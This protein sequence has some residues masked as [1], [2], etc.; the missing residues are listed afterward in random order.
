[1][2]EVEHLL[3]VVTFLAFRLKNGSAKPAEIVQDPTTAAFYP[4]SADAI[5]ALEAIEYITEYL[6]EDEEYKI[7]RRTNSPY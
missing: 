7:V 2:T 6:K 4:L 3:G 1:V 5:K